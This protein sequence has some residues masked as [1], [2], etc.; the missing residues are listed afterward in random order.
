MFRTQLQ[1]CLLCKNSCYLATGFTYNLTPC[2]NLVIGK[3]VGFTAFIN[4][5][6]VIQGRR[7]FQALTVGTI[8]EILYDPLHC[9]HVEL[10]HINY[11]A[12]SRYKQV[13]KQ[14]SFQT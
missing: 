4:R 8:E 12:S 9:W 10:G 6:Y 11:A 2:S 1:I 5:I 3:Q 13:M 7:T 14:A